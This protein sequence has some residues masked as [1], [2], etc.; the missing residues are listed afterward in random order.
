VVADGGRAENRLER[1]KNQTRAALIGAAQAFIAAGK[2][3]VPV[4]EITEAADVGI[5]TFY[6]HFDSKEQLFR[7]AVS[8][9]LD[10]HGALLDKLTEAIDD[11][12]ETFARS[13][14]FT[15]RLSRRQP[16]LGRLLV[17]V[18][19]D[20]LSSDIGLAPRALRDINAAIQAG[21]FTIEDPELAVALAAA[22]LS[23]VGQLLLD[24]PERDDA[25]TTDHMAEHLL[26]IYGVAA[27]EAHEISHRPLPDLD[28]LIPPDS[29]G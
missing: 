2:L 13:Y 10:A 1:R 11:P 5:G 18:G 19:M 15:G 7:A 20:L 28:A 16:D 9:A 26:R 6:N 8:D 12:A 25:A 24:Q 14:R 21:R 3:N 27:D 23:A 4:T 22:T 17:T 29:S